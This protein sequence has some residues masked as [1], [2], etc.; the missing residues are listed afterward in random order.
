MLT[1]LAR[2]WWLLL[3]NGTGAILFGLMAFAWPGITL[4]T[5]VVLY[6]AYCI[7]DGVTALAEATARDQ[8]GRAWGRMIFVGIVSIAVGVGAFIWP[9]IT[10]AALL[11]IIA[12]WAILRGVLEIIAAI[13]LRKVIHNEW[14]LIVAGVLSILFGVALLVKP[15]AGALAMVWLIGCFAIAH[16]ILRVALAFKLRSLGNALPAAAR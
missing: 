10:T 9:G 12:I 11:L 13:E 15:Q 5:L 2:K 16:G 14:L 3:I 4:L 1:V 8:E 7:V 6:G